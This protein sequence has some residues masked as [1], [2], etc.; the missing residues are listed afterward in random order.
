MSELLSEQILREIDEYSSSDEDD[1][2]NDVNIVNIEV[3]YEMIRGLREGSNLVWAME[4]KHLYYKNSFSQKTRLT[5]CKCY[6]KGCK[7][8]LYIREDDTAFRN[9]RID[10][11]KNHGSMY[12]DYKFMYC[13]NQMKDKAKTAL[14]STTTFEIYVEVV[15]E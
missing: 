10:H 3:L 6:K 2:N 15:N 9:G 12:V 14:A 11:A 13:F 7:A 8:R 1:L 4:E 5:A